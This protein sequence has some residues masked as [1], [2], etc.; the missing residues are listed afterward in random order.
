M[1]RNSWTDE[2]RDVTFALVYNC[3]LALLSPVV[4]AYLIYR[5][6]IVGKSRAGWRE[7]L[8]FID[9]ALG[10]RAP[11]QP[12]I[13]VHAV[14]AG[15]V[16][17]AE[18]ILRE[19]RA[20]EPLAKIVLSVT[21]VTGHEMA[22]KRD[23]EVD[24][25]FYFPFDV[26]TAVGRVLDTLKPSLFISVETELWPNLLWWAKRSGA[27]TMV[28]NGRLSVRS[29]RRSRLAR[30]LY[31]WMLR[32]VD[33][34]CAQSSQD[35][36][37]FIQA[38]AAERTVQI[39][40]NSKFD[41]AYPVVSEAEQRKLRQDLGFAQEAP[42]IVAGSTSPGEDE[43]VL[44]AFWQVRVSH[45]EARLLIAPRHPERAGEIAEIAQRRGYATVRRT[46]L[47]AATQAEEVARPGGSAQDRVVILDTIGELARVYAIAAVAFVGGSLVPR[48]GQN[49][50]QAI[51]Q[52]K[53]VLFGPH[54]HNC[55]DSEA[56]AL[57]EG[58]G[59]QVRDKESLADGI[60]GLLDAPERL[61]GIAQKGR[62]LI[63]SSRGAARRCALAAAELLS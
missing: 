16:A 29:L 22:H 13:W 58:V 63:E 4:I 42:I 25:V 57:A 26:P 17:A 56:V 37:R 52:G 7:R 12:L 49:I 34:I 28:A 55:R 48:G 45:R 43:V 35:A 2:R 40:G 44:D 59:F 33:W 24:G 15:E 38:G 46:E 39:V 18:P 6:V 8:G 11:E 3:L 32:H 50:L 61:E 27:K 53:A 54:M 60:S 47:L 31:R 5:L 9:P 30:P 10:R 20:V 1:P 19:L 51:A 21:T 14:S 62:D 41:E 36:E 23:L